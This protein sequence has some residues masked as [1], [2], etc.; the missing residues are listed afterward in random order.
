MM[1]TQFEVLQAET[2]EVWAPVDRSRD[3]NGE[4]GLIAGVETYAGRLSVA[5]EVAV[6][7]VSSV[8]VPRTHSSIKIRRRPQLILRFE[9]GQ[10]S[11]TMALDST[12][13][14]GFKVL[15]HCVLRD[16]HGITWLLV[17]DD[18]Q[19]GRE[20]LEAAGLPYRAESVLLVEMAPR[21]G[22]ATR[23]SRTLA[24][25]KI[26]VVYSYATPASDDRLTA[27]FKTA[28]DDYTMRVLQAACGE[29]D[30]RFGRP[31]F[32]PMKEQFSV[33][34]QE[35]AEAGGNGLMRTSRSQFAAIRSDC[36]T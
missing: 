10:E 35:R 11:P 24:A 31:D 23:L 25:A 34:L 28:D 16:C 18:D 4:R 13:R 17:V 22:A 15:A 30:D 1:N 6:P 8:V 26:D 9:K 19:L 12:N 32:P 7:S 29:A 36:M 5:A 2:R 33:V 20:M 21:V 3:W 14:R 27:V